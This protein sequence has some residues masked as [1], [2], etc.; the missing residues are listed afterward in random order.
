MISKICFPGI[1]GGILRNVCLKKWQLFVKKGESRHD[2]FE[3]T[4]Y[5]DR[6]FF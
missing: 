2:R 1:R 6:E 5:R 3:E 4:S